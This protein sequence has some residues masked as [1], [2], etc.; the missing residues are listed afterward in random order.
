MG[1]EHVLVDSSHLVGAVLA[2]YVVC[3]DVSIS[4]NLADKVVSGSLKDDAN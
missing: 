4:T 2:L 1:V 3:K